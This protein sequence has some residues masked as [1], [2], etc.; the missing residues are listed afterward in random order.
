MES[1]KILAFR[2]CWNL[3]SPCEECTSLKILFKIVLLLGWPSMFIKSLPSL[4]MLYE[5]LSMSSCYCHPRK[6]VFKSRL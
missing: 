6:C 2:L 1:M 4:C 5:L 3:K